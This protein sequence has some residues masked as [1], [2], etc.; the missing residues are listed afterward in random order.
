MVRTLEQRV[1]FAAAP[2]TVYELYM[3]AKKHST[4]IGGKVRVS[5]KVGSAFSAW[6]DYC[7]G[8]ILHLEP[9]RMVV[10][11]WR[12]S[13]WKKS[14][15]DSVLVLLFEKAGTGTMLTMIH[16]NVPDREAD[17]LAAGWQE[18]YWTPFGDALRG[19]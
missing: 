8:T 10:Q 19:P 15:P 11:T 7:T 1:P 4:A 14:D 12:A 17:A 18:H 13:D 16:A 2:K 5:K 6:D 9:G 3:D